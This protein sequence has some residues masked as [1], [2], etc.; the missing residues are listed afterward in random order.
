MRPWALLRHRAV[1]RALRGLIRS[2]RSL[3]PTGEHVLV[4]GWPQEE[5]N[6]VE[7][8]RHLGAQGVKVRWLLDQPPG[9]EVRDLLAT[10]PTVR[11]TRRLSAAGFLAFLTAPVTFVTHGLF[12]SAASPRRKTMVNLWH[13]DGPKRNYMPNGEPPPRCDYV[14]SCSTVFG[15]GKAAFLQVPDTHLLVTGNPRNDRLF[16]PVDADRLAALGLQPDRFVVYMP[17]YRSARALGSTVAWE[18]GGGEEDSRVEALAHLITA[19]SGANLK[20]VVKPH[21]LDAVGLSVPGALVLGDAELAGAGLNSYELLAAS[22]ALVTDYSSIWTDYLSTGKHVAFA[23]PDWEGYS[24][25]RGLDESVERSA[26][27]GPVVFSVEEF[28]AFFTA[29]ETAEPALVAQRERA[30]ETFGL[31]TE[32]G[33]CRRL[34]EALEDRGVRLTPG[35]R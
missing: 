25:T 22:H 8:V 32:E 11:T 29:I 13:G 20:V 15:R 23:V 33:N 17:T 5:G 9:T 21:P 16:R 27:P 4:Y 28:R 35:A 14:V 6:A 19:A 26:L 7:V 18:D 3:A 12:L 10:F 24:A 30:I 34:V 2:A 1:K 31:V